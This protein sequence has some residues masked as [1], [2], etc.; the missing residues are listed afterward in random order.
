MH[1]Q[2]DYFTLFYLLPLY[3]IYIC[4]L[5]PIPIYL[6]FNITHTAFRAPSAAI[7]QRHSC[8]HT[9][10]WGV[11]K[12]RRRGKLSPLNS[13]GSTPKSYSAT[14]FQENSKPAGLIGSVS[15]SNI[16]GGAYKP[17][18]TV[19]NMKRSKGAHSIRISGARNLRPSLV[20]GE[21]ILECCQASTFLP[22]CPQF[23][24]STCGG[25]FISISY[26]AI[27]LNRGWN[28]SCFEWNHSRIITK[29]SVR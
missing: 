13:P 14:I 24:T 2:R 28:R 27:V 17:L 26:H 9:M 11:P 10:S 1:R 5:G 3:I 19:G 15:T 12:S 8:A 29:R 25:L 18:K 16:K 23:Y 22:L 21:T 4:G 6:Q 7:A 20:S